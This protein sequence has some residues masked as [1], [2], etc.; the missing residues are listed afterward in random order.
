[1]KVFPAGA[2]IPSALLALAT[3]TGVRLNFSPS[4][5]VGVWLHEPISYVSIERGDWISVCPPASPA[6][7]AVVAM[8]ILPMG[9]CSGLNVAPL[10]KPVAAI[11]GDVVRLQ[12]GQSVMVNGLPLPNTAST[13]VLPAWPD[14][15]YTVQPGEVWLFSPR[16][17]KSF[18]S[19]YFGPVR[20]DQVQGKATPFITEVDDA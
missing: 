19:R 18:D 15:E 16:H 5:P 4:A 17:P 1:M 10:L 8:K 13:Q 12:D 20:I 6:T 9:N 3:I 11:A 14:G 7:R 2:L